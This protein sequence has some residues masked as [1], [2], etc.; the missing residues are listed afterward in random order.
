MQKLLA[1]L[2][3]RWLLPAAPGG[4]EHRRGGLVWQG[5]ELAWPAVG[6]V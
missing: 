3:R 2:T 4:V 6:P 5:F 1:R